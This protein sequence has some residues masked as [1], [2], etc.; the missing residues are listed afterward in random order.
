MKNRGA[1]N[2]EFWFLCYS[3]TT[4][5]ESPRVINVILPDQRHHFLLPLGYILTSFLLLAFIV[6][7]IILITRRRRSKG[8]TCNTAALLQVMYMGIYISESHLVF[9][10]CFV[11]WFQSFIRKHPWGEQRHTRTHIIPVLPLNTH[12]EESSYDSSSRSHSS[13]EEFE[14]DV[15][16]VNACSQEER[17][18]GELKTRV[19]RK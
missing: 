18:F 6:L 19:Q 2:A 14:M 11:L 1:L 12:S 16:E 5:A 13:S 10:V 3:D 17:R 9:F 7:I 4:K 15:A 8:L